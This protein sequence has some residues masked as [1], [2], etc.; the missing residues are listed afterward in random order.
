[1]SRFITVIIF[2]TWIDLIGEALLIFFLLQVFNCPHW[3]TDSTQ[4]WDSV[5][6]VTL[7]KV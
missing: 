1:M 6:K 2:V 7:E 4:C 5:I 3:H